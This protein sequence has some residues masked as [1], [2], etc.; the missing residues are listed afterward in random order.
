MVTLLKDTHFILGGDDVFGGSRILKSALFPSTDNSIW[1]LQKPPIWQIQRPPPLYNYYSS[2]WLVNVLHQ[3]PTIPSV[4]ENDAKYLTSK[5]HPTPTNEWPLYYVKKYLLFLTHSDPWCGEAI[6]LNNMNT[7]MVRAI[8][9]KQESCFGPVN[10]VPV[11]LPTI[12]AH[13]SQKN[14]HNSSENQGSYSTFFLETGV[15]R[16]LVHPVIVWGLL[17]K[18]RLHGN[19]NNREY[20]CSNYAL[21]IVNASVS[22]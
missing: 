6:T 17:I 13:L 5:H 11:G 18:L 2:K 12:S 22:Y 21:L 4:L 16:F 14:G 20:V 7:G 8:D 1:L 9:E 19:L 10:Y 3:T 15:R